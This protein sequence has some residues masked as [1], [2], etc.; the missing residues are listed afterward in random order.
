MPNADVPFAPE[1]QL[2][3]ELLV[4]LPKDDG[5]I[6]LQGAKTEQDWLPGNPSLALGSPA[7]PS[8]LR[9]ELVT[10]KLNKMFPYLWL[11][12]T[13]SSAH[14]T[15]I[16]AQ[17]VRGRSIIIAENPELH[18]VWI[19]SRLFLKP[20]PP[21]LLSHAFWRVHLAADGPGAG[22]LRPAAL[23]YMRSWSHLVKHESDFRLAQEEHLIP[24]GVTWPAFSAL[25]AGFARVA[26]EDVSPRYQYGEMRLSR[27]NLWARV[28]LGKW[29]F[30]K[31]AW[32]YS[33]VFGRYYAPVLFV[34]GILSVILSAMQV[35][36]Q[37]RPDWSEFLSASAWFAVVC[38]LFMALVILI[39]AGVL[40]GMLL[41]ELIFALRARIKARSING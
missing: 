25:I 22:D 34:F 37:T 14:V 20:I 19:E 23:G 27:L 7:L 9:S 2:Y 35:G 8:Y 36:S 32:Q 29:V 39:F 16:H 18:L 40:I 1:Q 41:N 24:D 15:Q 17:R 38:L 12:T 3:H 31:V 30:Q 26:D 5:R 6:G 4:R 13:Q 21:Y 33:E 10:P 11:V 28:A